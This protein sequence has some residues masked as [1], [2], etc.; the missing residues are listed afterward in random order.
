MET[1][2]HHRFADMSARKDSVFFAALIRAV[3]PM[4][5]WRLAILSQQKREASR[6]GSQERAGQCEDRAHAISM[7][8]RRGIARGW[9]TDDEANFA[10]CRR[11]AYPIKRRYSHITSHFG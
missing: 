1:A 4:K 8:D 6:A 2:A 9:R 5:P 11:L 7:T 10:A 3:V